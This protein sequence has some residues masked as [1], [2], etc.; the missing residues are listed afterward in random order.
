NGMRRNEI[1]RRIAGE[2]FGLDVRVP[3]YKEEAARGCAL[4]AMEL[5]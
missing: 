5:L 1:M 2:I 4:C 3:K